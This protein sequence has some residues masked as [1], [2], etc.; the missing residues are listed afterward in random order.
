MTTDSWLVI[1]SLSSTGSDGKIGACSTDVL[2]VSRV[3]TFGDSASVLRGK[4]LQ[5]KKERELESSK[6]SKSR[7]MLFVLKT[8]TKDKR[9]R[10]EKGKK[11]ESKNITRHV[12]KMQNHVK[13]EE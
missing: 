3:G 7:Q 4:K 9:Q 12:C 10:K 8:T 2:K 6:T 5:E 11:G 13:K 1:L